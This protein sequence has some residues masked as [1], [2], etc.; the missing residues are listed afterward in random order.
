MHY[1]FVTLKLFCSNAPCRITILSG[2]DEVIHV[3]TAHLC[4]STVYLHTKACSLRILAQYQSQTLYRII[5]LSSCYYQ[6]I[7]LSFIFTPLR[8]ISI[9]L[10][11]KNYGF[12]VPNAVLT[13]AS[14]FP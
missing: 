8:Q 14:N 6:T 1:K 5:N 4:H 3:C 11:D 10:H 13:F 9:T 12:P 2:T 7:S